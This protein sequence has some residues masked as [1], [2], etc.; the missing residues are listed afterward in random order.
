MLEEYRKNLKS[1]DPKERE[2]ACVG[3]FNMR[4]G[5][6]EALPELRR[7]VKSEK[8]KKVRDAARRAI[9]AIEEG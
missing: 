1:S 4:D 8:D 3:L 9:R 5:A 6:T 7:L 2:Q